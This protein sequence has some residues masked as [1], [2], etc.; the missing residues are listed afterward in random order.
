MQLRVLFPALF[1]SASSVLG[2]KLHLL[3]TQME[4]DTITTGSF[5]G[6]RETSENVKLALEVMSAKDAARLLDS[7]ESE[8]LAEAA[9]SLKPSLLGDILPLMKEEKAKIVL[10][11][12]LRKK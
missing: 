11:A 10:N 3:S 6:A 7:L 8:E 12:M 5:K 2:L 9:L 1:L 4:V